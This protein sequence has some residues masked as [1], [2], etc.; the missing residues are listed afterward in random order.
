MAGLGGLCWKTLRQ[1]VGAK[2]ENKI[3][4]FSNFD[5][6][7]ERNQLVGERFP[8]FPKFA[9][10]AKSFSTE[11]AGFGLSLRPPPKSALHKIGRTLFD[12]GEAVVCADTASA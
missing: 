11:R 12:G 7:N 6:V 9:A 3:P 1:R 5:G 8:T 4:S 10:A 2:W